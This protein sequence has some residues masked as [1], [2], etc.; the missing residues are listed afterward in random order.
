[1]LTDLTG[2]R[3]LE[4]PVL[5]TECVLSTMHPIE[6]INFAKS[7][8]TCDKITYSLFKRHRYF[9]S[10]EIG[11]IPRIWFRRPGFHY[12]SE[13]Q[14]SEPNQTPIQCLKIIQEL[15][16]D[17][18]CILNSKLTN[19]VFSI[20]SFCSTD[21]KNT[22]DWLKSRSSG[23][24]ILA[25][26]EGENVEEDLNYFLQEIKITKA[27]AIHVSGLK[28]LLP[29]IPRD[30]EYLEILHGQWI[31]LDILLSFNFAE[32][33]MQNLVL[34]NQDWN[35][36]FQKWMK[37]ECHLKLKSVKAQLNEEGVLENILEGIDF[38][39][40]NSPKEFSKQEGNVV[41]LHSGV[42]IV[43]NDEVV[44]SIFQLL[45]E[46]SLAILMEVHHVQ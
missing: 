43:R 16:D 28:N 19:V 5:V 36:F 34:T 25:C 31:T 29:G 3:F 33:Q 35:M 37:S 18:T 22:I 26:I 10:L 24:M 42:K 7:H 11:K 39:Y 13:A 32:L 45:I 1:M 8:P 30:L 27:L 6:I 38:T 14:N 4:L 21:N 2:F 15:F 46:G 9:I 12:V 40:I 41:L 44:A 20:D 23:T 17:S